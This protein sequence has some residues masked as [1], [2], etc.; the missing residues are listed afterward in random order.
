[1]DKIQ[2]V[3]IVAGMLTTDSSIPELV[4]NFKEKEAEEL[5]IGMI[6]FLICGISTWI[7]YGILRND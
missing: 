3:G 6:L 1:M 2:I 7:Y 4:K 5:S